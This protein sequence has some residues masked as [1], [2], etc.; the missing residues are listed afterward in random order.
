[1]QSS[2]LARLRTGT[3]S[4]S[5]LTCSHPAHPLH[6][7]CRQHEGAYHTA[8]HSFVINQL[9][10][11][12]GAWPSGSSVAACP[13]SPTW[14]SLQTL[15]Y[16]L[17]LCA[18]THRRFGPIAGFDQHVWPSRFMLSIRFKHWDNWAV[19]T[20]WWPFG[21]SHG[22]CCYTSYRCPPTFRKPPP[23]SCCTWVHLA[24]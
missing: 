9:G 12:S 20:A 11:D 15:H 14:P 24:L 8:S 4:N 16:H 18:R 19:V 17:Q 3:F 2:Y 1:M 5:T 23:G 6:Q 13:S 10:A 22:T 21:Q 7:P